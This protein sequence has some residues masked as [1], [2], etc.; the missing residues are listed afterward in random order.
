[1]VPVAEGKLLWRLFPGQG[2]P[3]VG[4][5]ESWVVQPYWLDKLMKFPKDNLVVVLKD[6]HRLVSFGTHKLDMVGYLANKPQS[7]FHIALVGNVKAQRPENKKAKFNTSKKGHMESFLEELLLNFQ[8]YQQFVNGFL[9]NSCLI[10]FYQLSRVP[11]ALEWTEGPVLHLHSQGDKWL[12]GLLQDRNVHKLPPDIV[13]NKKPVVMG[14]LLSVRGSS[15]VY[16]S[17]HKCM[18]LSPFVLLCC[19]SSLVTSTSTHSLWEQ[20]HTTTTP[21][22]PHPTTTTPPHHHHHHHHHHHQAPKWW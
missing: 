5:N 1:M 17:K 2:Y 11:G 16:H 14:Q 15:V 20:Q 9:T 22:P 13:I 8:P 7:I 19:S 10:Q 12:L 6:T 21:P 18:I 3:V 4:A